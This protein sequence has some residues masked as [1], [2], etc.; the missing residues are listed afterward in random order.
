[1]FGFCA[2][3]SL[4]MHATGLDTLAQQKRDEAGG[5]PLPGLGKRSRLDL[6]DAEEQEVA[7]STSERDV[8]SKGQARHYRSSRIDTPSHPGM[9]SFLRNGVTYDPFIFATGCP[10]SGCCL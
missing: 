9:Q 1:M 2:V 5:K 4:K 3:I 7:A 10:A 8:G 6:D